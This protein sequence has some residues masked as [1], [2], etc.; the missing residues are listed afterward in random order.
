MALLRPT[1]LAALLTSLALPALAADI[2]LERDAAG[3]PPLIVGIGSSSMNRS[4]PAMEKIA[5]EIGAT[6]LNRGDEG[7]TQRDI[8]QRVGSYFTPFLVK[9]GMLPAEGPVEL[10]LDGEFPTLSFAIKPT[11]VTILGVKGTLTRNGPENRYQFDR[12]EPGR[13]VVAQNR[14]RAIPTNPDIAALRPADPGL[15]DKVVMLNA[16]K[17]GIKQGHPTEI[18]A[19]DLDQLIGYFDDP[20]HQLLIWG[21]FEDVSWDPASPEFQKVLDLNAHLQA[22]W[23]ANYLDFR[24]WLL[25]PRPWTAAQIRPTPEDLDRQKA[26]RMPPSLFADD[27]HLKPEVYAAL[28]MDTVRPELV[29][30]VKQAAAN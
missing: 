29:K 18:M 9:G 28:V 6:Y 3:Q 22:Q 21:F 30:S 24:G 17:N 16:G 12:A 4:A 13:A 7:S 14:V 8:G 5:A 11:E 20:E 25:S 15:S 26:G 27:A 10:Q 23:P 1:L 2:R 19:R